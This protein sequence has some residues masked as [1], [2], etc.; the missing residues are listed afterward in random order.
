MKKGHKALVVDDVETNALV[1][2]VM[3]NNLGITDVSSAYNGRQALDMF[4]E[5]LKGG[6]PYSLVL[7]DFIMPQ[8]EGQEVVTH[9]RSQEKKRR[10]AKG[11]KAVI[12]MVTSL[13]S[14]A[15]IMYTMSHCD[16]NDYIVKPIA[17][18]M[19][20]SVLSEQGILV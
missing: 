2:E 18:D 20:R 9:M 17:P 12:I 11:D 7:M 16:C 10:R 19:L 4:D 15:D 1:L 8:M 5:A 6:T 3:L 14:S 13:N